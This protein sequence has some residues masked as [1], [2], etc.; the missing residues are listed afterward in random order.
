M[1]D[2]PASLDAVYRVSEVLDGERIA[3]AFIGGIALNAWAVPRATF[4]LDLTLSID[5]DRLI[6][7]FSALS[8]AHFEIDPPFLKGFRDRV[9]GMEK[10]HVH[11]PVGATLLAVDLFLASTPFLAAVVERHVSIDLGRG[12]IWLCTAADLILFKLLADRRKDLADIEN[13]V[14]VQGIPDP[15]YL[16]R[17]AD[18]LGVRE[19]LESLRKSNS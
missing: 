10:V 9:G 14:A 1:A 13:L 7:L 15:S 19:R 5:S 16:N 8:K 18:E 11:L 2:A 17:W 3:Y 4:D 12:P 6:G